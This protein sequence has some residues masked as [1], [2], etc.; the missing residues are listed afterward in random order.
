LAVSA[1]ISALR[2]HPVKGCRAI[3]LDRATLTRTG[4][5]WDREWMFVNDN[6]RFLTQREVPRLARIDA[7]VVNGELHLSSEGHPELRVPIDANEPMRVTIWSDTCLASRASVDTREWLHAVTGSAGQLVRGVREHERVS[8][9][10]FTGGDRGEVFFADAYALLVA[11][12]TSLADLNGRLE[13][14][15]PMNRFRPNVVL[16]GLEAFAEDGVEWLSLAVAGRGQV[17]LK[18]V[19]PCTRCIVTTTDQVTGER[20]GEEPLRTLRRFRWLP[21]LKGVAFGMNAIV[22]EGAGETLAVGDV[23]D[24]TWQRRP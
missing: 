14:P 21:A 22:V 11:S 15:L 12:P 23:F 9:P 3:E 17:R 19:K 5:Q 2:V 1:R 7:R 20:M 4:I 13:K 8:N 24:V 16:E 6:G 10:A 18:L